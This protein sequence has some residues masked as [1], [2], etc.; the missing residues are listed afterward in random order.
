VGSETI[1]LVED[2]ASVRTLVRGAL[3]KRGYT[4]LEARQAS[5]AM[6]ICQQHPGPIHLMLTDVV[7]PQTT[8]PGLA[9]SLKVLQPTIKVLYMSGYTDHAVFRNGALQGCLFKS[10]SLRRVWPVKC[11]R[12]WTKPKTR[13]DECALAIIE[14]Q[15]AIQVVPQ[16]VVTFVQG[17]PESYLEEPLLHR[18]TE[19]FAESV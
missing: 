10:P 9:E 14:L 8:G 4:V 3:E 17:F 12:F 6:G 13:V 7:M 16:P 5:E 11:K 19:P 1:L 15:V 2:E 18:A